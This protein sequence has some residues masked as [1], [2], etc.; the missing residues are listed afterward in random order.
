MGSETIM[1]IVDLFVFIFMRGLF[2]VWPT[3]E[4][5]DQS[6]HDPSKKAQASHEKPRTFFT[7]FL[8]TESRSRPKFPLLIHI[9]DSPVPTPT[10]SMHAQRT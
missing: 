10:R 7:A 8:R 9:H 3:E 1:T 4:K 6:F 2:A 5:Q